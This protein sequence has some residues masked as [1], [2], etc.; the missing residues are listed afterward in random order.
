ML[1]VADVWPIYMAEGKP[2]KKDAWK[3]RYVA[4]LHK[5]AALGGDPK[6]RGKGKMKPGHLAPLMFMR[7][8]DFGPETGNN[9]INDWYAEERKR[10]PDQAARAAAMFSGFL[11]WWE[12]A[13][14]TVHWS[15]RRAR[16]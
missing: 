10:A 2:R 1:T 5:A 4:D 7:L 15:I 16:G 9:V 14:N 8:A 3:P 13:R 6:K 11:A 12:R